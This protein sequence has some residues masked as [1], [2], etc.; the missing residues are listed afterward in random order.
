MAD[1]DIIARENLKDVYKNSL[2]GHMRLRIKHDIAMQ[3]GRAD[4][5]SET[6]GELKMQE[7][8]IMAYGDVYGLNQET[9]REHLTQT[10]ATAEKWQ[11]ETLGYYK[12]EFDGFDQ[13][14]LDAKEALLWLNA[15]YKNPLSLDEIKELYKYFSDAIQRAPHNVNF[16]CR[17]MHTMRTPL[18]AS[19]LNAK[20]FMQG[21]SKLNSV[22]KGLTEASLRHKKANQSKDHRL[23]GDEYQAIPEELKQQKRWACWKGVPDES[24]EGKLKKIP[25]NAKTG[26]QAMSN[27]PDTWTDY[28]TAL[29]MARSGKVNGLTFALGD[30]YFGVDI[31]GEQ[32]ALNDYKLGKKDNIIGEFADRLKSYT[33]TSVSGSGIHIVCKGKLPE[34][35]RRRGNVEMYEK[36]RFFVMT[37][38]AVSE[39]SAITDC[40]VSIEDLHT[41]YIGARQRI[42]PAIAP[43]ELGLSAREIIDL[44]ENAKSGQKFMDLNAGNWKGCGFDSQSSADL[45]FCRQLAFWTGGDKALMRE[46]FEASGLMREKWANHPTYAENT[47]DQAINSCS[48]FYKPPQEKPKQPIT[49]YYQSEFSS[50]R[51]LSAEAKGLLVEINKGLDRPMTI[52]EIKNKSKALGR[53]LEADPASAELGAKF[54]KFSKVTSGIKEAE[55]KNRCYNKPGREVKPPPKTAMKM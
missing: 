16:T 15:D 42:A 55:M 6:L 37:G 49:T 20:F 51:Y 4:E 30:G 11:N 26:G 22:A 14:T 9:A 23:R 43:S 48:S 24:R 38:N 36:G 54:R 12:N 27:T 18:P 50:F 13:L 31:D 17:V 33:E 25:I 40:T 41:K 21:F 8:K 35:G 45:S 52:E 29:K 46:I 53:Q 47:M 34:G 19:S 7:G 39:F 28:E 2:D 10:S 32:A 44:A 3:R 1:S 5:I